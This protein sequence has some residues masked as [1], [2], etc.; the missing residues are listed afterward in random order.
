[1]RTKARERPWSRSESSLSLP[2]GERQ[3]VPYEERFITQN[4]ELCTTPERRALYRTEIP[5]FPA[6][7][8]MR[9]DVGCSPSCGSGLIA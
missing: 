3:T 8:V 2:N 6:S 7:N 9:G 4:E 5:I 1:M